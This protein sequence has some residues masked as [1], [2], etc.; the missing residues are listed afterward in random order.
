MAPSIIGLDDDYD[1]FFP[2]LD[3]DLAV[4]SLWESQWGEGGSEKA[5][6]VHQKTNNEFVFFCETNRPEPIDPSKD[7]NNFAIKFF[8]ENGQHNEGI[9]TYGTIEDQFASKM[10]LTDTDEYLTVGTTETGV[11]S[12]IFVKRLNESPKSGFIL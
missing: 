8:D 9:P 10:S 3:I 12:E 2:K 4:V 5:V 11:S 1:L 6:S 7:K